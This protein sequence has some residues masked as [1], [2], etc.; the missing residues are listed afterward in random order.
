MGENFRKSGGLIVMSGILDV[1]W[2]Q[3]TAYCPTFLNVDVS[4][5]V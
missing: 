1:D 4:T 5:G 3:K 2:K